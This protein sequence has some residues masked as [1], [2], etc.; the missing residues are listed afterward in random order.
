MLCNAS[1]ISEVWG[2]FHDSEEGLLR[3][4]TL[5]Y[6]NINIMKNQRHFLIYSALSKSIPFRPDS[7]ELYPVYFYRFHSSEKTDG[8]AQLPPTP[9]RSA[10][11]G[12]INTAG[13]N[14]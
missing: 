8:N 13:Q 3:V 5:G 12:W 11:R 6:V 10:L 7:H 1:R 2:V 14:V 9:D 4:N